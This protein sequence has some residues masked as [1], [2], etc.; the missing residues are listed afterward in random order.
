MYVTL[1]HACSGINAGLVMKMDFSTGTTIGWQGAIRSDMT[2]PTGG[3][4][5][6]AGATLATPGWCQGGGGTIGY[7]MG[8]FSSVELLVGGDNHYVYISDNGSH[9]ITRL[10]K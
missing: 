7:R 3:D 6:C 5:G 2:L 4:P 1:Y 8:Q 10:P 9:R